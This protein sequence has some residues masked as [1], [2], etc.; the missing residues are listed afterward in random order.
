MLQFEKERKERPSKCWKL[1]GICPVNLFRAR[2]IFFK[3]LQE[4]RLSGTG[5]LKLLVAK[6]RDDKLV[7]AEQFRSI[8]PPNELFLKL[9]KLRDG[10]FAKEWGMV[11]TK[12]LEWP[13]KKLN[14]DKL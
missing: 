14:F 1:S 2:L 12:S 8:M 5:P 4:G 7:K 6:S 9:S 10:E 11:P 13:R 3:F